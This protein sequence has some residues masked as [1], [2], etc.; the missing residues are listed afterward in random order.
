MEGFT[1]FCVWFLFGALVVEYGWK[2]WKKYTEG[3][4]K[5]EEDNTEELTLS[6]LSG[7]GK[8]RSKRNKGKQLE[9]EK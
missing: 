2:G 3:K 7:E 8:R 9:E 6:P 1:A 5:L 4:V